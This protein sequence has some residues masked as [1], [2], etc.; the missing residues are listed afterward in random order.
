MLMISIC[1]Q[2]FRG[3]YYSYLIDLNWGWKTNVKYDIE[4]HHPKYLNA[5]N[6]YECVGLNFELN[7]KILV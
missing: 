1:S 3:I 2:M 4:S 7:M 5:R 6:R